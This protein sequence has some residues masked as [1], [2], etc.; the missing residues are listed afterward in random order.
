MSRTQ[1]EKYERYTAELNLQAADSAIYG[2]LDDA[3]QD[4]DVRRP[5][6]LPVPVWDFL[7]EPRIQVRVGGVDPETVRRYAHI[8]LAGGQFDDPLVA[9]TT[10]RQP[11]YLLADGFHRLESHLLAYQELCEHPDDYDALEN[12]E[13]LLITRAEIRYGGYLD[14]LEY[15]ETANI[16]HGKQLTMADR[17][18]IFFRRTTRQHPW[19]YAA[20]NAIAQVLGVSHRTVQRWRE[21]VLELA[22]DNEW[23]QLSA[24]ATVRLGRDGR[25]IDVSSLQ[26]ARRPQFDDEDLR[27]AK[28]VARHLHVLQQELRDLAF[29]DEADE[30]ARWLE[31]W[32]QRWNIPLGHLSK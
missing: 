15:A 4:L 32:C 30:I 13:H 3:L 2:A 25:A 24:N 28:R 18:N 29:P 22:P 12:P 9:F 1:R 20:N 16:S 26:E 17:F 14:A 31:A 10:E 27:R 21:R 8:L 5:R 23:A 11:P 19:I 7:I 6:I